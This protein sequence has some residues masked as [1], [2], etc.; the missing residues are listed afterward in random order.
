MF[1]PILYKIAIP[2]LAKR[3]IG[4][5]YESNASCKTII[6]KITA[7]T[8]YINSRGL[9]EKVWKNQIEKVAMDCA[10][11]VIASVD[12]ISITMN[13]DTQDDHPR[14]LV[15]SDEYMPTT[16]LIVIGVQ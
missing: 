11:D 4:A 8:T 5:T 12:I 9:G 7:I 14:Y 10:P 3:N 13:G 2:I 15:S 16:G 6:H 1:E